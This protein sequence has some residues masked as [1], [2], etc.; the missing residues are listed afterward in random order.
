MSKRRQKRTGERRE[1]SHVRFTVDN[2]LFV[3]DFADGT[4]SRNLNRIV[5]EYRRIAQRVQHNVPR[6]TSVQ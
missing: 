1:E 5:D 4:I 3:R 2:Y 6:G